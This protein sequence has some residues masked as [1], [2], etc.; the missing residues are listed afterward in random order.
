MILLMVDTQNLFYSVR[1]AYGAGSRIDF[2]KLRDAAR[3]KRRQKVKPIAYLAKYGDDNSTAL[4]TALRTLGYSVRVHGVKKDGQGNYQ[5][6]N[7]DT[8]LAMDTI[9]TV[10]NE[11]NV[12]TVVVASGDSDFIPLYDRLRKRGVRVEVVAFK[13]SLGN[14]VAQHVDEV[15][16]LDESVIFEGD[17]KLARSNER[18]A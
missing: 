7:T 6:T 1:D 12:K 18:G 8:Y 17:T 11:P 4:E 5:K 16:L 9:D 10:F 14:D 2:K 15:R 3:N 13:D